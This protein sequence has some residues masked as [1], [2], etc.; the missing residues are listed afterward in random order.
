MKKKLVYEHND[1]SGGSV[2]TLKCSENSRMEIRMVLPD[3]GDFNVELGLKPYDDNCLRSVL[4]YVTIAK[5][6]GS[7]E[8]C[9]NFGIQHDSLML[10]EMYHANFSLNGSHVYGVQW[11]KNLFEWFVDN[12]TV[13][14]IERSVNS[15]NGQKVFPFDYKFQI[16]MKIF[17]P[18]IYVDNDQDTITKV[19]YIR[20]YNFTSEPK[21]I[22]SNLVQSLTITIIIVLVVVI[23]ILVILLSIIKL[24]RDK[25]MHKLTVENKYHDIQLDRGNAYA[26]YNYHD[27]NDEDPNYECI[28]DENY[29]RYLEIEGTLDSNN[30]YLE[31]EHFV[32]PINDDL[33]MP[34]KSS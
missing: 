12:I 9:M 17:K 24:R 30:H 19:D 34:K 2:T 8:R 18:D 1:Y 14:S 3:H 6:K 23:I 22:E 31:I 27:T 16:N 26:E 32:N 13:H 4:G 21:Q 10:N 15:N 20:V 7:C 28:R 29:N 25:Q 11:N 5:M 33:N